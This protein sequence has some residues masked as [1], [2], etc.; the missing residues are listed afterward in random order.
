[1]RLQITDA[2]K[3]LI[4]INVVMFIGTMTVGNGQLFNEWFT[5]YFPKNDAFM[6]WQIVTHMFMHGGGTHLLFNMFALWMFGTA[7]ERQLGTKRF[8]FIYFSAGLGALL[9]Q[10]G[11][12]YVDF[13][14]SFQAISDMNLNSELLDKILNIDTR[15]GNYLK[16]EL[17]EKGMLPLFNEYGFTGNVSQENFRALF[18]MN[19]VT[20]S[21]MVGAS[22][23]IM[24]I[25]AAFGMMNPN[26]ELMMI[27]LPIP[28]KAKYFIPGI[29][30]LDVISAFTGQS[31]FSP[32]NTAYMAHVGG[33]VVGFLIMWFWKKSS[34]NKYRWDK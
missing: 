18:D 15:D 23:C 1:M 31:F 33:A 2:V 27:F 21:A 30:L 10:L 22:G 3:H 34:M 26:A 4:I 6:P 13:Y 11:Y 16:G 9:F 28:I 24:G 14:Q 7:V 32:S 5:L 20:K 29:I 8:L 12:Y 17:L 25:L 19:V